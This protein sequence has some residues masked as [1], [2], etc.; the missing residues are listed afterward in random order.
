MKVYLF[1][2]DSGQ[3]QGESFADANEVSD[4]NGVT[5]LPPPEKQSGQV[6][7]YDRRLG[8]WKL[9]PIDSLRNPENLQ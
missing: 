7:V 4:D 1:D 9:V 6:P 8:R 5:K 3:Y 2:I